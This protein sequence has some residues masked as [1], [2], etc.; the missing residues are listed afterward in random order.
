VLD[1][2]QDP[3]L[4]RIRSIT[5]Q[6]VKSVLCVPMMVRNRVA[7]AIYLDTQGP[8]QILGDKERAFIESFASQAA[9][10]IE[11]ARLFGQMKAENFRLHQEV[12]GRFKELIGTSPPMRRVQKL[13]AG[14][15]GNDS[16]V[17]LTGESGTG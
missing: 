5:M 7:G 15:L 1:V 4:S 10:A 14:V 11:N 17:L 9:V 3:V 13:M 12:A 2:E 6:R 16:T 8:T